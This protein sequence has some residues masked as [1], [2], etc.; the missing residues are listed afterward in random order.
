MDVTVN[1]AL[2]C[3]QL[4]LSLMQT[5]FMFYY[6]KVF[7]NI[8]KIDQFWFGVGQIFFAVWNA[9]NDPLLG[10]AQVSNRLYLGSTANATMKDDFTPTKEWFNLGNAPGFIDLIFF[11]YLSCGCL[12]SAVHIGEMTWLMGY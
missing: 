8:Y 5:F 6:V 1:G 7:L 3:G 12:I 2:F 10:Y 11:S 9:I 4:A